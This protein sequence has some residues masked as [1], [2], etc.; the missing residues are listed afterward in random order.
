[1]TEIEK[2]EII[3][4][5]SNS[6][7]DQIVKFAADKEYDLDIVFAVIIAA[8]YDNILDAKLGLI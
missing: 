1:M 2:M 4:L 6:R 7:I 5:V 3:K 8:V